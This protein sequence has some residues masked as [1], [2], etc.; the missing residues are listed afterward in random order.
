MFTFIMTLVG[1]FFGE[2]FGIARVILYDRF[3]R[4]IPNYAFEFEKEPQHYGPGAV[5]GI[6][7][8]ESEYRKNYISIKKSGRVPLHDLTTKIHFN[9]KNE[10]Q[11]YQTLG[12]KTGIFKLKI[13]CVLDHSPTPK[14]SQ[15]ELIKTKEEFLKDRRERGFFIP[16]S[17]MEKLK[18]LSPIKVKVEYTWEGKTGADIWGFDFSDE[19]EVRFGPLRLT[20]W[21]KAKLFLKK[22]F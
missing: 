2:V 5:I 9:T 19:N 16:D 17:N 21:Q 12:L 6:Y 13:E 22:I 20:L 14:E 7:E 3:K 4:P 18:I 10:R 1:A 8:T 15:L 11:Y